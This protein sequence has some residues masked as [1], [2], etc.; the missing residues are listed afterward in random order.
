MLSH[1]ALQHF[2]RVCPEQR[3]LPA[4]YKSHLQVHTTMTLSSVPTMVTSTAIVPYDPDLPI[5][6]KDGMVLL[7]TASKNVR[8]CLLCNNTSSSKFYQVCE[9]GCLSCEV[10]KDKFACDDF[11]FKNTRRGKKCIQCN[12]A[13]L[14]IPIFNKAYTELACK[15]VDMDVEINHGLQQVKNH[16]YVTEG[17]ANGEVAPNWVPISRDQAMKEALN[18]LKTD[19]NLAALDPRNKHKKKKV[20]TREDFY[21]EEEWEE[22]QQ[23]QADKKQERSDKAKERKRKLE[24][25]DQLVEELEECKKKIRI[26]EQGHLDTGY[27]QVPLPL[28][29]D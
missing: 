13:C 14:D 7:G 16:G 27:M 29:V 2:F 26:L 3:A 24:H 23:E 22:F 19:L 1:G 4:H 11:Y 12:G 18:F 17:M 6:M 25:Y 10:C 28:Q 8:K 20:P 15:V 5:H 9:A 21:T